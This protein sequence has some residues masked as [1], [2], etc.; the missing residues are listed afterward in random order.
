MFRNHTESIYELTHGKGFK[1][2]PDAGLESQESKLLACKLW[3]KNMK[4]K[5]G[6]DHMRAK[7]FKIFSLKP[8][9]FI[10][11]YII[12]CNCIKCVW[13]MLEYVLLFKKTK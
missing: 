11:Y 6:Q 7:V 10:L 1:R 9:Y 4:I 12:W 8:G 3:G 2:A 5:E 13:K